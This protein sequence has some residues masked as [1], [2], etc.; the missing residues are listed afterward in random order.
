MLVKIVLDAGHHYGTPGRRCLKRFDPKETREWTLNARVADYVEQFLKEDY[1]GFEILRVDDRT[2][3]KEVSLRERTNKANSWGADV[4]ISIHHDA[5]INGGKGGG[6]T[7]FRHP[8]AHLMTHAKA[9][10]LY[11][12][13]IAETGLRGNRATPVNTYNFHMLRETKAMAVLI[14]G[15]FMDSEVDVPIILTDK[16]ARGYARA[17]V[18]WLVSEFKLKANPIKPTPTP[19]PPIKK[20]FFRVVVG[21]Y[22]ERSN[23]EQMQDK[24][25]KAGF[26]SFLLYVEE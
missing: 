11:N 6:I 1:I 18:N 21:S 7:V 24:L 25:K 9:T 22:S 13:L 4:L 3:K 23:A 26:D 15:G 5:G 10:A 20:G 12:N 8:Q 2:G 16:H 14:E 19:I 17:I